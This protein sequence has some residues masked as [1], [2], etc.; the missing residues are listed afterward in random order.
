MPIEPVPSMP[1]SICIPDSSGL[2]DA[3]YAVHQLVV[4]TLAETFGTTAGP[5]APSAEEG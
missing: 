1:V 2:S 4:A 5:A 3:A